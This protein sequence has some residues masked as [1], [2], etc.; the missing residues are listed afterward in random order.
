MERRCFP[1]AV[2]GANVYI[3]LRMCRSLPALD[4]AVGEV[5]YLDIPEEIEETESVLLHSLSR[6]DLSRLLRQPQAFHEVESD[7]PSA[8][9]SVLERL[10]RRLSPLRLEDSAG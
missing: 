8:V 3:A 5:V 6:L 2:D 4:L 9:A 7:D 10:S 1:H